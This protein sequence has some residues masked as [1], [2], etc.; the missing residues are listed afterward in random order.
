M[1]KKL[2]TSIISISFISS[3]SWSQVQITNYDT[4]EYKQEFILNGGLDFS[5][6]AVENSILSKFYRGGFIDDQMKDNSFSKHRAIN[7][8]GMDISGDFIYRNYTKKLFKNKNWGMQFQL[9]YYN[10][11]GILYS[12]D[13]F[14][15]AFYGNDR[16]VGDTIDMS[17]TDISFVSFQ[18]FGFGL[19][20]AKTKSSVSLN[21]YNISNRVSGDFRDLQIA[22]SSDGMEV[23]V[24]MDGE[25]DVKKNNK[26]NQGFGFGIDADFRF[27]VAWYKERIAKIQFLAK[28]VGFGYMIEDQKRYSFDTTIN[29][30]GFEFKDLIGDNAILSDSVNLLDTLGIASSDVNP[31][32][33]LPGFIQ[34]G[35]MIDRNSK[36]K[37]QEFFGIR[38][39]PTLIYS[40]YIFAGA[41]YK[42]MDWLNVGASLSYGGFAGFKTG[43]YANISFAKFHAGLGTDNLIGALSKKGNGQSLYLK[44]RCTI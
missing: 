20:D 4:L 1:I 2:F 28:N 5:A 39:Y 33:M 10:F 9:G 11:G 22:Q 13:L 6:S 29:Y 21:V 36:Y 18:K 14:G 32:F 16:Y 27:S 24:V 17:G 40:P 31:V 42:A 15:L 34:I 38:V 8:A 12:D 30:T 25:V 44:L 43:I 26:F 35:K 41:N 37:L 7:R 3:V 23:N 19:V